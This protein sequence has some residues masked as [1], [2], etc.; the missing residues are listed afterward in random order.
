MCVI[1]SCCCWWHKVTGH[2]SLSHMSPAA[3]CSTSNNPVGGTRSGVLGDSVTKMGLRYCNVESYIH[4]Y[5]V[6][7]H[8]SLIPLFLH[9]RDIVMS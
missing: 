8:P 6:K 7:L 1:V 3:A 2:V 9:F 5:L 4:T